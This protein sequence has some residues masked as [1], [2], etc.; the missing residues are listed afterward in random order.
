MTAALQDLLHQA[1]ITCKHN[2]ARLSEKRKLV[3]QTLFE[4]DSALSAYEIIDHCRHHHNIT[5]APMSVYRILTFL[6]QNHLVH[7][8]NLANKFV[9]CAHI[10]CNHDHGTPQFII[11]QTCQSV[12]ELMLDS[13][14]MDAINA[15]VTPL[16][17]EL[18]SP[19]LELLGLCKACR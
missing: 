6:E 17:Y 18:P 4:A 1:E 9:V 3:L 19:Q 12:R 16:G 11:C 13:S 10:S 2:K 15:Q 5:L 7:K 14:I 8:L